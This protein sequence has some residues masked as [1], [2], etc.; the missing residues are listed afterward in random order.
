MM[1]MQMLQ[2]FHDEKERSQAKAKLVEG[3][4]GETAASGVCP[5]TRD[6]V[7]RRF[8]RTRKAQSFMP[9]KVRQVVDEILSGKHIPGEQ[10]PPQVP[11]QQG[12][13]PGQ[14][15][16]KG[17]KKAAALAASTA[18]VPEEAQPKAAEFTIETVV[19]EVVDFQDCMVDDTHPG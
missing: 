6:I 1:V 15:K 7:K 17:G 4:L 18:S 10:P 19:E 2:V 16:K 8:A 9:F 11:K 5:P 14:P 3:A 12:L 13:V